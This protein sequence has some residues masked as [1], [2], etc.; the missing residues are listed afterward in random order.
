[1]EVLPKTDCKWLMEW[2]F[3]VIVADKVENV[4]SDELFYQF[5]AGKLKLSEEA[6]IQE[7][8]V[9]SMDPVSITKELFAV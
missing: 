6:V 2:E 1:M 9:Y 4:L 7:V 8:F 5:I 3:N